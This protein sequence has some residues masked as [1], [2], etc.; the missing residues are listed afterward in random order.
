MWLLSSVEGA[1][2]DFGFFPMV[3]LQSSRDQCL[4]GRLAYEIH[5]IFSESERRGLHT[6]LCDRWFRG[7][8]LSLYHTAIIELIRS[9]VRGSANYFALIANFRNAF[10][11]VL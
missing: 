6:D 11:Q 9:L 5:T 8:V 1:V 2:V 3:L 10:H 7:L 4:A